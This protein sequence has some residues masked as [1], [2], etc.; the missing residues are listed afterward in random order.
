MIFNLRHL[1]EKETT[2]LSHAR[3]ALGIFCTMFISCLFFL[4]HGFIPFIQIPNSFNLS[5][6]YNYLREKNDEV[7]K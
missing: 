3:F 5:S 4:V 1:K 6:M 2:Y 7:S